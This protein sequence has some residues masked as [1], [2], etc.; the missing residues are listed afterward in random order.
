LIKKDK[1]VLDAIKGIFIHG[2]RSF[3]EILKELK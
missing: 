3:L 1:I 2:Q